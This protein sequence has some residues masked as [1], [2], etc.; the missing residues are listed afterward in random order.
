MPKGYLPNLLRAC[1]CAAA[2]FPVAAY[3]SFNAAPCKSDEIACNFQMTGI[4]L[5]IVGIP[6]SGVIFILLHLGFCNPER[7]KAKQMFLGGLIGII[8]FELSA[9]AAAL[10]GA[11]GK[12]SFGHNQYWPLM[13]F[14]FVY[15]TCA[16]IASQY[17]R[18]SP[19][20]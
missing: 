19:D 7:S 17:A 2:L 8:A 4:L 20:S 11:W 3:A 5:G 14:V 1:L 18:S 12:S 16:I 15:V 13:G 6:I 10:M 9:F